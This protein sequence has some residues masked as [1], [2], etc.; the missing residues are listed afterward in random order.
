MVPLRLANIPNTTHQLPHFCEVARIPGIV[1]LR[2]VYAVP[3]T[4]LEM[5]LIFDR[6][7]FKQ[8]PTSLAAMWDPQ[9]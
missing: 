6:R 1:R 3:Y 2:E 9:Q 4:Y 8:P 7:Q 5:G